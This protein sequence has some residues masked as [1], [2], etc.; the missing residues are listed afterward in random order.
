MVCVVLTMADTWPG[1][2]I[3]VLFIFDMIMGVDY[4]MYFVFGSIIVPIGI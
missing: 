2:F 4:G 1:S 3:I